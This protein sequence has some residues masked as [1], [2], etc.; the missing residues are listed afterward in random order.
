MAKS[1]RTRPISSITTTPGARL[2]DSDLM[3]AEASPVESSEHQD[4]ANTASR[5]QN[6]FLRLTPEDLLQMFA[7]RADV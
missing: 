4:N 1:G 3:D 7:L 6:W 2:K 5:S